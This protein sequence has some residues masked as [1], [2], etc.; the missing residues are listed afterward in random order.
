MLSSKVTRSL[1]KGSKKACELATG[2]VERVTS[3]NKCTDIDLTT[4]E[5]ACIEIMKKHDDCA[6]HWCNVNEEGKNNLHA[7]LGIKHHV[8]KDIFLNYMKRMQAF[9]AFI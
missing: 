9:F 1:Q 3:F 4:L 8:H 5:V 2:K 6:S 7:L